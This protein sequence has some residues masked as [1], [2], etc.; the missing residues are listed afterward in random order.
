MQAAP[1]VTLKNRVQAAAVGR[2]AVWGDLRIFFF[3][4]SSKKRCEPLQVGAAAGRNVKEKGKVG[5][6]R[7][8]G[9]CG[10]EVGLSARGD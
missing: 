4:N 1:V 2:H 7:F 8:G 3:A 5:D 9:N 6:A 10:V